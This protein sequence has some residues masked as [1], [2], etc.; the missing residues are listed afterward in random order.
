MREPPAD[1]SMLLPKVTEL[2]LEPDDKAIVL[3][4]LAES[5]RAG[6][7]KLIEFAKHLNA[8]PSNHND[9]VDA[10]LSAMH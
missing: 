8:W 4:A 7:D 9:F 6:T 5:N 10:T 3:L 2:V 1:L